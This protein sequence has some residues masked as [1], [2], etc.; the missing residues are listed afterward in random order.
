MAQTVIHHFNNG[1]IFIGVFGY[2]L[3]NLCTDEPA[4]DNDHIF[5]RRYPFLQPRN[6][7][8]TFR[9]GLDIFKVV[10]F[11]KGGYSR[12]RSRCK[13]KLSVRQFGSGF[14]CNCCVFQVN[15][16]YFVY[17]NFPSCLDK[18]SR[19]HFI[20]GNTFQIVKYIGDAAGYKPVFFFLDHEERCLGI[21]FLG[22]NSG[23]QP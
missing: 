21:L 6:V 9:D 4:A 5:C 22:S 2:L 1:N 8:I 15:F 3:G 16:D 12:R 23:D 17:K 7:V 14:G 20:L 19:P 10:T 11:D 13:N 18:G